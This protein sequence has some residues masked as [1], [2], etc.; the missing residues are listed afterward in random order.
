MGVACS[1]LLRSVVIEPRSNPVAG[2]CREEIP[3]KEILFTDTNATEKMQPIVVTVSKR[4]YLGYIQ[5][6]LGSS[7]CD[8]S[9]YD[10]I[11]AEVNREVIAYQG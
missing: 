6:Y 10:S 8:S 9:I 3:F 4:D 11:A 5:T 7:V 1:L 2:E